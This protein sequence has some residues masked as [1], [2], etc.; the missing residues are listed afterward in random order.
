MDT[1]EPFHIEIFMESELLSNI[2]KH[3]MVPKHSILSEGE[4]SEL[5]EK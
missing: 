1:L 2:T 5:L 4:K 3:D